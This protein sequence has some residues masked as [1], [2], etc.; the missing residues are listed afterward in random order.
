MKILAL[1]TSSPMCS[2]ALNINGKVI[3]KSDARP[4]IHANVILDFVNAL[5]AEAELALSDIDAIAFGRG[6][7]GFT[8]LR[9]GASVTQGLAFGASLPVRP[10]SSLLAIAHQV[11]EKL[12]ADKVAVL[13]DARMNEIYFAECMKQSGQWSLLAKESLL[14]P[15]KINLDLNPEWAVAGSALTMYLAQL[16]LN[17]NQHP[18]RDEAAL[19]LAKDIAVLAEHVDNVTYDQA[20]PFYLRDKVVG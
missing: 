10:V 9:I 15:E 18:Q 12:S 17:I 13:V 1:E 11:G 3:D 5:L 16:P 19:P 2:V 6:P 8:G 4:R 20:L 14:A 7:G